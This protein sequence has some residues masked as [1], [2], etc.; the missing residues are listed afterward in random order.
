MA[1]FAYHLELNNDPSN[2]RD[3]ISLGRNRTRH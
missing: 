1:I 3:V 2:G